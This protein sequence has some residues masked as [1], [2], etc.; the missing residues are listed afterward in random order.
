MKSGRSRRPHG[1]GSIYRL[2]ILRS[3]S[4]VDPAAHTAG[5]VWIEHRRRHHTCRS[6]TPC[7]AIGTRVAVVTVD[8]AAT[9]DRAEDS[10]EDRAAAI[11]AAGVRTA[12]ITTVRA[13]SACRNRR[14]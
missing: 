5:W 7:P 3:R 12:A 14:H 13:L 10:A 1:S 8:N 2:Q 4:L 9:K 11:A 6:A